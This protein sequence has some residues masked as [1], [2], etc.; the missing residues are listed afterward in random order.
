MKK[1]KLINTFIFSIFAIACL[2][3]TIYIFTLDFEKQ[4]TE[5]V[6]DSILSV[7]EYAY[8]EGQRDAI[9]GDIRIRKTFNGDW[10]WIKSPWDD[11]EIIP[12]FNKLSQYLDN[13]GEK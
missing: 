7:T 2:T 6:V 11:D 5:E 1:K 4:T 9:E 8:M 13:L 3:M 10:E 12:E